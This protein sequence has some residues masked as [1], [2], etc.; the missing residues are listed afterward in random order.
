VLQGKAI[1]AV[2]DEPDVLETMVEVLESCRV[3][4]AGHYEQALSLLETRSYDMVIL[5]VMGVRGLQLLEHAVKRNFP[6]VMFTAPA[7]HPEY[8]LKSL[9]RGAVSYVSKED[10]VHL[11]SL[12]TD[13]F[14]ILERGE[15]PWRY[16]MKRLEPLL[17]DRFAPE[18]RDR[19]RRLCE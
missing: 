5:D 17:D 10:L 2:D 16:T 15:S 9:E 6:A 8:V 7:L 11:D 19:Y 12:L 4:T 18:W 13:L 14:A 3:D 1:L